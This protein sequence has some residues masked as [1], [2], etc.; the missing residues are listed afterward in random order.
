MKLT[1]QHLTGFLAVNHFVKTYQAFDPVGLFLAVITDL[2]IVNRYLYSDKLTYLYIT[3][4]HGTVY[5]HLLC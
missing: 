5:A 3:C 1:S 4:I 2:L